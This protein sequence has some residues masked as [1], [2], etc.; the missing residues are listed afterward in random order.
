MAKK[1]LIF[2]TA[3]GANYSLDVKNIEIWVTA[4]FN[5]N[6]SSIATV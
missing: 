6:F 3:M 4:F 2:S 5:H 1:I